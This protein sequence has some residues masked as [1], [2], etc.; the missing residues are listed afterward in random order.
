MLA[1]ILARVAVPAG[2]AS[3]HRRGASADAISPAEIAARII[4]A[5]AAVDADLKG[6]ITI[7][8]VT[9]RLPPYVAEVPQLLR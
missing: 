4:A 3:A 9:R 8:E 1:W 5:I 6:A 2:Y 7:V